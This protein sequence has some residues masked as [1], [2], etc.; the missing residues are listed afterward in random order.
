MMAGE[1]FLIVV[2]PTSRSGNPNSLKSSTNRCY[3]RFR[4][5]AGL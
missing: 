2:L 5:S 4:D 1:H 3:L